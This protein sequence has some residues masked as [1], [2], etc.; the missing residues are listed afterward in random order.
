M[1]MLI[2]NWRKLHPVDSQL[3]ST[4][5]RKS[6]RNIIFSPLHCQ[7]FYSIPPNVQPDVVAKIAIQNKVSNIPKSLEGG[8]GKV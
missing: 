3:L 1:R 8:K 2:S 5:L 4:I 7:Q 6:P